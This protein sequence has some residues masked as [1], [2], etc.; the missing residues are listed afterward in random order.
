MPCRHPFQIGRHCLLRHSGE[1]LHEF[2]G[3]LPEA[4]GFLEF[5]DYRRPEMS[6]H[7]R[8]GEGPVKDSVCLEAEVTDQRLQPV[9]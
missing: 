7:L 6:C 5:S 1:G 3:D 9:A 8:I 2:E 4:I